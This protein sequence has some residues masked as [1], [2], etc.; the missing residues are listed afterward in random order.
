MSETQ[1]EKLTPFAQQL[2]KG[3]TPEEKHLWYDYLKKLPC[4]VNR[5]KIFGNYIADFYIDSAKLVIE[6]DGAQHYEDE[7]SLQDRERDD[8][9]RSH[10]ITVIRYSNQDVKHNFY[11]VCM[12]IQKLLPLEGKGDRNAVDE[13]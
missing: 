10:G 1:N 9:F 12:D 13:V 6:L 8:W 4:I 7:A 2:R 3:M 11:G 5:Q